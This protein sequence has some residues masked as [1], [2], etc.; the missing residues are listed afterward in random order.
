[1]LLSGK[2]RKHRIGVKRKGGF[3]EE[4]ITTLNE[5]NETETCLCG[6]QSKYVSVGQGLEWDK[7]FP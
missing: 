3:Q 7:N 2:W 5:N 1:M 6:V 4:F